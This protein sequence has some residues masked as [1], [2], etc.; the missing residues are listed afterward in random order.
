MFLQAGFSYQSNFFNTELFKRLII[1]YS[2]GSS[3]LLTNDQVDDRTFRASSTTVQSIDVDASYTN[4]YPFPNIPYNEPILFQDETTP[5]NRDNGN[6]FY[7]QFQFQAKA[8]GVYDFKFSFSLDVTHNC[9]TASA[10]VP[11]YYELGTIYIVSSSFGNDTPIASIPVILKP[12]DS[13]TNVADALNVSAGSTNLVNQGATTAIYSGAGNATI[14]LPPV[15]D[16]TSKAFWVVKKGSGGTLRIEPHADEL[17][18]GTDHYNINNQYG[19][20]Y[21][22]CDGTEWYALTNK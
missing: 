3:L 9:S 15:A 5:P 20:A 17:V 8:N 13:S 18:D 2:G 4:N 14:T 6:V 12:S 7:N 11:R 19:T 1:P 16:S 22:V 21:L 10:Y